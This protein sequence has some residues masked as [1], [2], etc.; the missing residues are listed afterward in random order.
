MSTCI[1]SR[2]VKIPKSLISREC[3]EKDLIIKDDR[4][5]EFATRDP[6]ICYTETP[7]SYL[8]PRMYGLK[9][10][11]KNNLQFEQRLDFGERIKVSFNGKLR[12][13]QVPVVE[14]ACESLKCYEGT[15]LHLYCGF[16]KTTCASNI[17]CTLGYKTLILVHTSALAL[18]WKERIEQFVEN[19]S[20][21]YIRQN[22]FDIENKTHVVALMQSVCKRDYGKN[23]FDSFGL[24]I[25]DEAHHVCANELSKCLNKA[26]SRYRLGLTATPYRKDG[27]TPYLFY[28]IGD[29]SSSIERNNKTQELRTEFIT[30]TDGPD[31]VHTIRRAGGKTSINIAKMIND[32]CESKERMKCVIDSIV[33]KYKEGRHLIVLSDRRGHLKTMSKNLEKD[34]INDFGFLI[35]GTKDSESE[36]IS[37]RK[38]IFATYSYCSEGVDIPSLD[39]LILTT[40]RRDVVQCVG[41][42]LRKY[43]GKK[44]PLVVDFVDI[45]NVFKTQSYARSRYYKNLGSHIYYYN[46]DLSLKTSRKRKI[47]K[48]DENQPSLLLKFLKKS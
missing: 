6:M 43:D 47:E 25:V 22:V 37:K 9:Y 8:V 1:V 32:L 7:S 2:R 27:Y 40:P 45:Q 41:R 46:Q 38:I 15:V 20:V 35:G 11:K 28:S 4:S 34:N 5:S 19:S 10:I 23:A 42:I 33:S 17:S 16:G 24:T 44:N 39:T 12:P 29:I 48:Q 3:I 18:Q 30:I 31:E 13:Q 21:G 36:E 14:N 26:G